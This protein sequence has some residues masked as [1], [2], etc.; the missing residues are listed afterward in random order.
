MESLWFASFVFAF[1]GALGCTGLFA[2]ATHPSAP[3]G[4]RIDGNP[5]FP[6]ILGGLAVLVGTVIAIWVLGIA[7]ATRHMVLG[8]CLIF[9]AGLLGDLAQQRP[10]SL[11]AQAVVTLFAASSGSLE[12]R[13]LGQITFPG[14]GLALAVVAIFVITRA[15]NGLAD[16]PGFRATYTFVALTWFVMAAAMSANDLAFRVAVVLQ[17]AIGGYLVCNFVLLGR[18]FRHVFL[19]SSGGLMIAFA[20]GWLALVVTQGPGRSFPVYA[21]LWVLYLPLADW[22]SVLL[23][24]IARREDLFER[25]DKHLHHS[26]K[27]H[28]MKTGQ[29]FASMLTTSG[30]CALFGFAGWR[31]ELPPILMYGLA[32]A[33]FLAYHLWITRQ[34]RRVSGFVVFTA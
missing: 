16:L 29:V 2:L 3:L 24:R 8:M 4:F 20:V 25:S 21:A 12:F 23:R 26:L 15:I 32:L 19:G 7:P 30:L 22:C 9:A 34:W 31:W 11:I 14:L 13:Q 10:T 5:A 18:P 33:L 1:G 6:P 17:S 28:G 27:L